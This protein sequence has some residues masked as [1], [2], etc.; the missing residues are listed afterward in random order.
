M[1]IAGY[2]MSKNCADQVFSEA[3]FKDKNG[4]GQVGVVE[5]HDCFSANE[6]RAPGS[7]RLCL[8]I[9]TCSLSQVITYEALG[10]CEKGQAHK[11]VERGDNT[12]SSR[13][14]WWLSFH[15]SQPH[16]VVEST[17]ST[18]AG[19]SRLRATHRAPLGLACTFTLPVS[20][21]LFLLR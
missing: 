4:R 10:L 5:L 16:S 8:Q 2:A 21:P 14:S 19:A 1:D 13:S 6:V 12:V 3:G 15:D 11:M 17:L 9:L 18:L 20:S 7:H